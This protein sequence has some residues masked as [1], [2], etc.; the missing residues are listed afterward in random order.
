MRKN[1]LLLIIAFVAALV[2]NETNFYFLKKTLPEKI[3][4]DATIHTNDDVSYLSPAKH[5][6]DT[7]IWKDNSPGRQSYFL[8]PPGYGLLYLFF[9]YVFGAGS[10]LVALKYFQLLLFSV[11]AVLLYRLAAFFIADKKINLLLFLLYGVSPF[12]IGFLYYTLTEAITPALVIGYSYFLFAAFF[13][14]SKIHKKSYY[15]IAAL[16][17]CFLLLVRPVLGVLGV[18]F[19]GV[20]AIEKWQ[21]K[22]KIMAMLYYGGVAL[23]GLAGWE[24]RNYGIAKEFVGLHPI[25]YAEA[26]TIYRPPHEKIWEFYECWNIPNEDFHTM[27]AEIWENAIKGDTATTHL[28]MA[29]ALIPADVLRLCD[30]GKIIAA[31]KQYQA[32]ILIQKKYY[33]Q[34][35]PMPAEIGVAENEVVATFIQFKNQYAAAFPFRYYVFVPVKNYLRLS[36]HS[37]L[38]LY[39]FQLTFRGA[40]WAEVIRYFF[41]ALHSLLY[42]SLPFFVL[43]NRKNKQLL[44][45]S[46]GALIYILLLVAFFKDWEERYTLPILPIVFIVFFYTISKSTFISDRLNLKKIT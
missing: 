42:L 33:D 12:A 11:S 13:S 6:Y 19:L 26:N 32:T 3:R 17:L 21:L 4:D 40:I 43:L 14:K 36:L 18:A 5:F 9:I 27:M 28:N 2:W 1:I 22:I 25:Y 16:I 8:R 34:D 29:I 39:I 7:G 15:F 35:K 10:A 46:A 37:N 24:I 38:S 45:L 30:K 23:S 20:L 44:A 31:F 41:F